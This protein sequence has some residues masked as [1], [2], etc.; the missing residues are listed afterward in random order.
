MVV[1]FTYPDKSVCYR[2]LHTVAA[3]YEEEGKLWA[4]V[5]EAKDVFSDWKTFEIIACELLGPGHMISLNE[6]ETGR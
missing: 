6:T 3:I 4:R 5:H 1:K 2:A